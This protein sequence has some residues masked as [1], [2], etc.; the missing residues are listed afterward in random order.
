MYDLSA[1]RRQCQPRQPE[2]TCEQ[3]KLLAPYFA[4]LAR[5]ERERIERRVRA[6]QGRN[7]VQ[8]IKGQCSDRYI[9]QEIEA[10]MLR[11]L[12]EVQI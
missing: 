10:E 11:D 8:V 1:V 6:W 3:R 7:S 5:I 4:L 2:L 9:D 12:D